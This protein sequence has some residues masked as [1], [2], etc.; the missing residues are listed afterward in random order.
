M[1]FSLDCL[2]IS[3]VHYR[4]LNP[5]DIFNR[6]LVDFQD[7]FM[8]FYLPLPVVPNLLNTLIFEGMNDLNCPWLKLEGTQW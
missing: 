8:P 7:G 2:N 5:H 1:T 6:T 4:S 3:V